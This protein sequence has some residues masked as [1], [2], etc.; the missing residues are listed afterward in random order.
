[1]YMY[2]YAYMHIYLLFHTPRLRSRPKTMRLHSE[3]RKICEALL[4][5]RPAHPTRFV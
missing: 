1:M 3:T 2:T 5:A 4:T